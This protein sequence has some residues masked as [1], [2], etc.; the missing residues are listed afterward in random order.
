MLL[1]TQDAGYLH[2]PIVWEKLNQVDND[3]VFY[4]ANFT[5]YESPSLLSPVLSS[6]VSAIGDTISNIFSSQIQ[7]DIQPGKLKIR[8][9]GNVEDVKGDTLVVSQ[10]ELEQQLLIEQRIQEELRVSKEE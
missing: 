9:F 8:C 3:T 4:R 2:E 1:K 10:A 6:A 7:T 5:P